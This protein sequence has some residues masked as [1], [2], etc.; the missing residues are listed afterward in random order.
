MG[1]QYHA[2]GNLRPVPVLSATVFMTTHP[3]THSIAT[4]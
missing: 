3:V 1:W 2:M 4:N